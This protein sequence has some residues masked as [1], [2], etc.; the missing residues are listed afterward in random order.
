[1]KHFDLSLY[2]VTDRSLSLG[3]PLEYVVEEAVKGGV[4][5]VQLRE[6]ECSSKEFYLQAMALKKCLKPYNIPLI[7]NDRL[8]IALACDAEGLHIGQSDLPYE[9]ARKILGKDKIIGLSVENKQDAL[10]ANKLDVDY[11]G[12]SPVFDTPTK[13]D[14]AQEL[15]LAGVHEISLV[16]KHPG[17][18]IGG[19]NNS[20]ALKIIQAGADGIS[21]VSAIMSASE[22]RQA[23]SELYDIVT[24]MEK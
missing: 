12:I 18:G 19:I 14:T 17:V 16:S 8:D 6:K 7:I 11:I 10:D 3:R 23:A 5:M 2:L 15:G 21:V 24:G 4:T 22:P 9:V 13:T 1:M 20:N